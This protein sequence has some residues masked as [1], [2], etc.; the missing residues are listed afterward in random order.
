[1]MMKLRVTPA[2]VITTNRVDPPRWMDYEHDEVSKLL[3]P[4]FKKVSFSVN[5]ISITQNTEIAS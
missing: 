1:M 2:V 3:D 4:Q 5:C